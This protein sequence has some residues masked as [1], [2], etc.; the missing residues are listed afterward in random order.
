MLPTFLV[1]FIKLLKDSVRSTIS[2]R[3][4]TQISVGNASSIGILRHPRTVCR[5]VI[6]ALVQFGTNAKV[7]GEEAYGIRTTA[8]HGLRGADRL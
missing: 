8:R 6:S 1:A 3:F 2:A 7:L 5:F 4:A